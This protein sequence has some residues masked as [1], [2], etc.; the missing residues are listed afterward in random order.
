MTDSG[1]MKT[2]VDARKRAF[3]S[4]LQTLK[5]QGCSLLVVG[6]APDFVHEAV[7]REML[8]D[9]T[10]QTRRRLIVTT[11]REV[12]IA[13]TLLSTAA[14]QLDPTTVKVLSFNGATRSTTAHAP[15]PETQIPINHVAGT[16]L[17]D[18]GIAISDAIAE[19]E[20]QAP[21]LAPA[22]LR[23]CLDS[24]TPLIDYGRETVFQ[25]LDLLNGRIRHASGMGHVHLP[26]E[27]DSE[28]VHLLAPVFDAVVE[29][30]VQE[31]EPQQRWHLTEADLSS[32]W[33]TQ[34]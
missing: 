1:E 33:M 13:C 14:Q 19:F 18:L 9:S 31:N 11:D 28:L 4:A 26:V 15:P 27:R 7:C 22:E 8:G 10:T 5:Q 34:V 25:F 17:T 21:D 2:A 12:S 6:T 23:V 32:G 20:A 16:T 24:L 3:V 29:L 30:R